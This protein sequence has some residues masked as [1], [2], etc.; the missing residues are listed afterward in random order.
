MACPICQKR[1]A[2]RFCPARGDE[3]C[4]V[5]CGTEREVTIDCPSDCPYLI[6]SR[7]YDLERRK[8]DRS[9]IPFA[10]VKIPSSF[11]SAHGPLL[12]TITYAICLFAREDSRT[13]DTDVLAS[14]QTLAEAY[15]TL[16]SGIYYEKPLDYRLQREL[17]GRLKAAFDQYKREEAQRTGVSSV[18]D[19]DFRDALILFAQLGAS[20][21]NGRPKGRAFLDVLRS[22]IKSEDFSKPQSNLVRLP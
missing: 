7:S 3:I 5:C 9:K 20:Y 12:N 15:R 2:K 16:S 14:L 18:R 13:V 10:D 22:Q 21:L 11:A 4:S 1:N 17:Y 6:A 8:F 19:A